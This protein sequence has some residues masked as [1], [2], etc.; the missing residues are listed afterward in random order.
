M[1]VI[2]FMFTLI[3]L[4]AWTAGRAHA[5]EYGKPGY[6]F[7]CAG[8]QA[9]TAPD[10]LAV[11]N[12]DESSK[13]YGKVVTA[14]PFAAPNSIGNEPHHIGL[15]EDGRVV[16]CGGLLSVLKGQNEI[17]FFDVSDPNAPKFICSAN[18]PLSSITDE[19]HALAEG[20]YLITMMG[21]PAGHA[22]DE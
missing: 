8:D 20:G 12:F 9:G 6:L 11:I 10:F 3:A 1:R 17:F 22:P 16:G 21:G 4:F 18:P 13:D 14:V 5:E 7:I 19:F 15:S 2:A